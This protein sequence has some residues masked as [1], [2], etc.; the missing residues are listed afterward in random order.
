MYFGLHPERE[1]ASC[2]ANLSLIEGELGICVQGFDPML[3][4]N[5]QVKSMSY[6]W[7]NSTIGDG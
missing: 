2:G 7:D 1:I 5:T 4:E 3:A 6:F